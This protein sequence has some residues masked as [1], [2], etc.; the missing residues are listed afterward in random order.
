MIHAAEKT[1]DIVVHASLVSQDLYLRELLNDNVQRQELRQ[2]PSTF[3]VD[4]MEKSVNMAGNVAD[5]HNASMGQQELDDYLY[6]SLHGLPPI[7]LDTLVNPRDDLT[8]IIPNMGKR[9]SSEN[10]HSV[11]V[12][13]TDVSTNVV[14]NTQIDDL[15]SQESDGMIMSSP[16]L[17]ERAHVVPEDANTKADEM[18]F[19]YSQMYVSPRANGYYNQ[20]ATSSKLS[21]AELTTQPSV[22]GD[23]TPSYLPSNVLSPQQISYQYAFAADIRHAYRLSEE[24]HPSSYSEWLTP[25]I[26]SGAQREVSRRSGCNWVSW[27]NCC[28]F[29][30]CSWIAG[31]CFFIFFIVLTIYEH[32]GWSYS[33]G[34]AI[35]LLIFGIFMALSPQMYL[36]ID[37]C[38]DATRNIRSHSFSVQMP[39][40]SIGIFEG[41]YSYLILGDSHKRCSPCGWA[42]P[43]LIGYECIL[44][45][46]HMMEMADIPVLAFFL[47]LYVMWFSQLFCCCKTN[48]FNGPVWMLYWVMNIQ[49]VIFSILLHLKLTIRD[50]NMLIVFSPFFLTV[51][52]ALFAFFFIWCCEDHDKIVLFLVAVAASIPCLFFIFIGLYI[53]NKDSPG[54]LVWAPSFAV[55]M[56]PFWIIFSLAYLGVM[57]IPSRFRAGAPEVNTED[58]LTV[59]YDQSFVFVPTKST[60]T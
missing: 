14:P 58:V 15:A 33:D 13:H 52:L 16:G 55:A 22:L 17:V 10:T 56:I 6:S 46:I 50:Y 53:H 34:A 8:E 24:P 7:E 48:Q 43:V 28:V 32:K 23:C 30:L 27:L 42:L 29:D 5:C 19:L 9:T 40:Q 44:A 25:R 21:T 60:R 12:S 49:V 1:N 11:D 36:V 31:T 18:A 4:K 35:P 41:V 57:F 47:P 39:E 51:S 38:T 59:Q 3:T 26:A 37:K 54:S 20:Y 45:S 2:Q